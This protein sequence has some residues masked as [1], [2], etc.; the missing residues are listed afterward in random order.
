MV[1][2]HVQHTEQQQADAREVAG[3]PPG[4]S[5]PALVAAVDDAPQPDR[6]KASSHG[7]QQV[8]HQQGCQ[9]SST[10]SRGQKACMATGVLISNHSQMEARAAC[11]HD[12]THLTLHM[13]HHHDCHHGGHTVLEHGQSSTYYWCCNKR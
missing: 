13:A 12:L 1:D 11:P 10:G 9:Q 8:H 6:G 2:E 7:Q 5:I 4:H 3:H